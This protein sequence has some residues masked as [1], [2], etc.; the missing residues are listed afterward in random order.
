[1]MI[2]HDLG[3][4]GPIIQDAAFIRIPASIKTLG[5]TRLD[6]TDRGIATGWRW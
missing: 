5:M 1:M 3:A 6:P 4:S 2:A